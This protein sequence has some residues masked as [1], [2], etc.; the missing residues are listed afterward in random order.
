[1]FLCFDKL[2]FDTKILRIWVVEVSDDTADV[3]PPA[4]LS[5]SAVDPDRGPTAGGESVL[6]HGTGFQP[7]SRIMLGTQQADPVF[8]V[9]D[10]LI[11]VTTPPSP[12]GLVSLRITRPDGEELSL[13]AAFLYLADLRVDAILPS[14]GALDGG[15]PVTIRGRGFLAGS[16]V[17]IGSRAASAVE[18]LSDD[19]L[20][21]LTPPGVPG[22]A[23][24]FVASD[25]GSASLPMAFTYREPPRLD[26]A[27]PPI[28]LV[29]GGDERPRPRAR[30]R[31]GL[32]G[33][34]R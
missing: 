28:G 6:I 16:R 34:L 9:N 3:E 22:G 31:R 4:G 27:L 25:S 1:M 33:L 18:H 23:S 5:V 2:R 24:V 29:E 12:P 15:E 21:A 13:P 7:G 26:V 17:Y 20:V 11:S 10:H 14:D 19:T 30:A 32:R 8:V